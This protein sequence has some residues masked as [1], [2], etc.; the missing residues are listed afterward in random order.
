MTTK[1]GQ[2]IEAKNDANLYVPVSCTDEGV[3][4]SSL[5]ATDPTGA[6]QSLGCNAVGVL[7]TTFTPQDKT[8][9]G[10]ILTGSLTPILQ[11][12][13]PYNV[14]SRIW[15]VTTEPATSTTQVTSTNSNAVLTTGTTAT[16][17]AN[18]TSRRRLRYRAGMGGRCR[19]TAVWNTDDTK[20]FTSSIGIGIVG[21]EGLFFT[22]TNAGMFIER[23]SPTPG[24]DLKVAQAGWDDPCDGSDGSNMPE[25][26]FNTGNVF[27]IS[28]QFLGYGAVNFSIENPETGEFQI[29]HTL[30]YANTAIV[31]F[32]SN[33][34]LP[35]SA[36]ITNS[37]TIV[38]QT[39]SLASCAL[40]VEGM[41]KRTGILNSFTNTKAI[42][43]KDGNLN[44]LSIRNNP[45]LIGATK[46]NRSQVFPKM[47][48]LAVINGVANSSATIY[49]TMNA[50]VTAPTFINL[51][52][53]GKVLTSIVATDVAGT[54]V[55]D[56]Q[57]L[58]A[59]SMGVNMRQVIYLTDF[60]NDL[61]LNPSDVLTISATTTS[62]GTAANVLVSLMF[63]E[64]L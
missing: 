21:T 39:L 40:F 56:G 22:R 5:V 29:V 31:P 9:F 63:V 51:G 62:A 55:A 20:A 57:V 24:A 34:V 45:T 4:R 27:E 28:Y 15:T 19:F 26:K 46:T 36:Q 42:E 64:D 37:A 17:S 13:F 41:L 60:E 10:E 58:L 2:A 59:L 61:F 14:N 47:L 18:I 32:L 30:K 33:P 49:L 6:D 52:D 44:I 7:E 1:S 54:V 11:E 35:F 50:T 8:A 48:S 53:D 12:T 43:L 3:L 16:G 38:N 23:K 25:I